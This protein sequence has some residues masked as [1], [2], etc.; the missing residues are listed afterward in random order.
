MGTKIWVYWGLVG[1]VGCGSSVDG[2]VGEDGESV[3]QTD[4]ALF[5]EEG[6]VWSSPTIPVCWLSDENATER[7]WVRRAVEAAFEKHT[8]LNFTGWQRCQEEDFHTVIIDMRTENWPKVKSQRW[9]GD[10]NMLLNSF[11]GAARDLGDDDAADDFPDCWTE[12]P[13]GSALK[14]GISGKVWATTHQY[15]IEVI[16]LHEFF[17]MVGGAHEQNR[18]DTPSWCDEPQDSWGDREFGYWDATSISNYCNPR[19]NGD[20][21]LSQLDYSGLNSLYGWTSNDRVWYGLGNARIYGDIDHDQILFEQKV[22]DHTG[23]YTVFTGDFDA[24]GADDVVLY[25]P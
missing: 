9:G 7:G 25:R 20:G 12:S 6:Y 18:D 4:Q 2:G 8:N 13:N 15:C 3:S 1:V 19:W 14:G 11:V 17:H 16:A 10:A 22:E 24:N 21:L 5:I 23:N